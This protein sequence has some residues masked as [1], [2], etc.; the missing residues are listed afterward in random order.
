MKKYFINVT[1]LATATT[2]VSCQKEDGFTPKGN[3]ISIGQ[4]SVGS[5]AESRAAGVEV[6]ELPPLKT[7][8]LELNITETVSPMDAAVSRAGEVTPQVLQKEGFI[9]NGHVPYRSDGGSTH[10]MVNNVAKYVASPTDPE[11]HNWQLTDS[12]NWIDEQVHTFWAH[13]GTPIDF[14][15]ESPYSTAKFTYTN[16]GREDLMFA[17]ATQKYSTTV[18]PKETEIEK[19][20]FS[21]ALA[22]ISFDVSGVTFYED[23]DPDENVTDYQPMKADR[24]IITNVSV[25]S[26]SS[27]TCNINGSSY[28]W[29]EKAKMIP[30]SAY[31]PDC[32]M[33]FIIPQSKAIETES[34]EA[35]T[36]STTKRNITIAVLDKLTLST[37]VFSVEVDF[38]I[39]ATEWKEGNNYKYN[40]TGRINLPYAK[41]ILIKD[42]DFVKAHYWSAAK[43]MTDIRYLKKFTI[44]WYNG[45]L[46]SKGQFAG[47]SMEPS[48]IPLP[49]KSNDP[50]S[51]YMDITSN[52]WHS[53]FSNLALSFSMPSKDKPAKDG[54]KGTYDDK[55][56]YCT[57]TFDVDNLYPTLETPNQ[58]IDIWVVFWADNNGNAEWHL[59]DLQITIEEYR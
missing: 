35:I 47:I 46:G 17:Y 10:F 11:T 40:L 33:G 55:T 38:G 19:L 53:D 12:H 18:G 23:I 8:E 26:Y 48:K 30:V 9:L 15:T 6:Y 28:E 2:V 13:Y 42:V 20:Q 39:G 50:P 45:P 41:P 58:P 52:K 7:D 37:H 34:A 22:G 59:R 24:A 56:G 3:L 31:A 43:I 5:H 57:A 44:S 32:K 16:E 1:V 25:E 4:I 21:H 27:A 51:N 14:T 49:E 54:S 29:T 36:T